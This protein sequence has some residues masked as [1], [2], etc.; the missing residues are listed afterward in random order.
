M[1]MKLR[2]MLRSCAALTEPAVTPFPSVLLIVA[3][4]RAIRS[5]SG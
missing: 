5:I 2:P 4:R 3:N 1:A